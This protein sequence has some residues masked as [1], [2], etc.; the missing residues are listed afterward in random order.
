MADKLLFGE[1]GRELDGEQF[2]QAVAGL[3]IL[4]SLERAGAPPRRRSPRGG[5][6]R[7]RRTSHRRTFSPDP[8]TTSRLSL[9]R[10]TGRDVA[11]LDRVL[12]EDLL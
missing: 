2:A 8:E 11:H 10:G 5:A 4:G 6:S 3:G 7:F 12:V 1:F 9:P